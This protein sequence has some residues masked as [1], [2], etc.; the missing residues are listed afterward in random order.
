MNITSNKKYIL[1][2]NPTTKE[3][4]VNSESNGVIATP[5]SNKYFESDDKEDINN[6]IKA[7]NLTEKE[8]SKKNKILNKI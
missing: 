6:K 2:W 5:D 8:F 4:I 3:V 7:E 1:V